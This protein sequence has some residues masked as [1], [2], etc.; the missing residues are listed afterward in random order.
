MSKA[1]FSFVDNSNIDDVQSTANNASSKADNAQTA[2]DEAQEA[3]DE[4]KGIASET[5]QH[6]W[7]KSRGADTGAHISEQT[8][9]DYES[10]PSGGNLLANSNG[11]AVRDGADDLATFTKDGSDIYDGDGNSVAHYGETVRIGQESDKHLILKN[12]AFEVHDE[13]GSVPFVVS[14]D[15]SLK[16]V[17]RGI[18]IRI[19]AKSSQGYTARI[20]RQFL[21]GII[22]DNKIYVGVSTSTYPSSLD[23]TQYVTMPASPT[24]FPTSP[25]SIT[26]DNVTFSA[27][28][29]SPSVVEITAVNYSN[30]VKYLEFAYTESYYETD[31]K[32]NDATLAITNYSVDLSDTTGTS[33]PSYCYGRVYGHNVSLV[34]GVYNTNAIPSG[35]VIYQGT[36][37]D[38]QPAS[39][40]TLIGLT[41][42]GKPV[43]GQIYS[44]GSITVWNTTGAAL[45][46]NSSNALTLNASY[47]WGVL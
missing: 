45:S 37:G 19:D 44:N 8:Q 14:T 32:V 28:Y 10:N 16:S 22:S 17:H 21:K 26:I 34:L 18:G 40:A 36:L 29:K 4:A 35:G 30:V 5:A 12:T 38:F 2:A 23:L 11:V 33:N 13:D 31:I 46:T 27:V 3:A 1:S 24:S 41:S 15:K 42:N 9:S 6:F 20:S 7:F 47:I 43:I 39:T 25:V